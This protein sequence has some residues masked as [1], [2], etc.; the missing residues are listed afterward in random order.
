MK[1]ITK[2]IKRIVFITVCTSL[3]CSNIIMADEGQN[4]DGIDSPV[5]DIFLNE[6]NDL[7]IET[8]DV[9][10]TS[11]ITYKTEGLTITQIG[12]NGDVLYQIPFVEMGVPQTTLVNGIETNIFTIPHSVIESLAN[13][14][15]SNFAQSI[16]DALNGIGQCNLRVDS[17]MAVYHNGIKQPG[18]YGNV[19]GLY[20]SMEELM[21]AEA[22]RDRFGIMTH[23]NWRLRLNRLLAENELPDGIKP[24]IDKNG[25]ISFGAEELQPVVLDYTKDLKKHTTGDAK[26]GV[27]IGQ[28][29]CNSENQ[30]YFETGNYSNT[31]NVGH[32]IPSSEYLKNEI[33]YSNW[34]AYADVWGRVEVRIDGCPVTFKWEAVPQRE[35]TE[36]ITDANG[37]T[38]TK[39]IIIPPVIE[40]SD[41]FVGGMAATGFEFFN[42]AACNKF[43][44]ASVY[45]RAVNM[46]GVAFTH[47]GGATVSASIDSA[48]SKNVNYIE[49]PEQ[50]AK[51]IIPRVVWVKD[52][53][54]IIKEKQ[55]LE[56]QIGALYRENTKTK[57][58]FLM[59]DG[60]TLMN[61]TKFTGCSFWGDLEE[62][63][64][65]YKEVLAMGPEGVVGSGQTYA[66]GK[67]TKEG[68]EYLRKHDVPTGSSE[69]EK[70]IPP[71]TDN[72]N[73]YTSVTLS[74]TPAMQKGAGA[75][76]FGSGSGTPP[77]GATG[78]STSHCSRPENEPVFV[79][80]PVVSPV[81]IRNTRDLQDNNV[82]NSTSIVSKGNDE[83]NN[84]NKAYTQLYRDANNIDNDSTQLILDNTYYIHWD[85]D[86]IS[87]H[88]KKISNEPEDL[89]GYTTEQ[90]YK[91]DDSSPNHSGRHYDKYVKDKWMKFPFDVVYD[92]V[93][94][95]TSPK[96][97]TVGTKSSVG[98]TVLNITGD[99]T[100]W[101]KIKKPNKYDD[102]D[103]GSQINHWRN[104]PFYIPS[105][106]REIKTGNIYYKS[107]A[108]NT[109]GELGK[110]FDEL[111]E[112]KNIHYNYS[113]DGHGASYVATFEVPVQLS[114]IIYDFTITGL[115][116]GGVYQSDASGKNINA[117]C[118]T[119][120]ELKAGPLNRIGSPSIRY[121]VDGSKTT[122][123]PVNQTLIMRDGKSNIWG[124]M[125][126]AWKGTNISFTIKTIAN[127]WRNKGDYL[128]I[129]P[130]FTLV[131]N[132][133]K[134]LKQ[135]DNELKIYYHNTYGSGRFI[136]YG[137]KEDKAPENWNLTKIADK[138]FDKSYYLK[139][140]TDTANG[141]KARLYH[142]G[143]WANYSANKWNDF[144]GSS[145]MTETEILN[146][147]S[148][149]NCLSEI[150]LRPEL[151]LLSGEYEQLRSNIKDS[152]K[153]Y[154][155]LNTYEKSGS[156]NY[157]KENYTNSD[158][159]K[160]RYSMQQ[161]FGQYNIPADL[162]I[163][164]NKKYQ[165]TYGTDFD[166]DKY[167]DEHNGI[168]E[169]DKIFIKGGY[170][171][172]NFDIV[173]Y[174]EGKP[175]LV[176]KG[177][178]G[179][180]MWQKEG[181]ENKK[182][183]DDPTN[184]DPSNPNGPASEYKD[185]DV[186]VI[187]LNRNIKDK[188]SSGLFNVN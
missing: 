47:S 63:R 171:I 71:T 107:E 148:R 162:F 178:G 78:I 45:T 119:K 26:T 118:K 81:S 88:L 141:G 7:C 22:W 24:I 16:I 143:N 104:T 130:R 68:K 59:I 64:P 76:E 124:K 149:S 173:A 174:E 2:K 99:Y 131:T 168:Q 10:R 111:E 33:K 36:T 155:D 58:D 15:S 165:E 138:T 25:K 11:N 49:W 46:N 109:D 158:R 55:S 69:Q 39:T 23:F 151:R 70:Q 51:D 167:I 164:D 83:L 6:N 60:V 113:L 21:N 163:V 187:D 121:L 97:E 79:H 19:D 144:G 125:G 65:T 122:S 98:G 186:I 181:Y 66:Y 117:L 38:T 179:G 41:D 156:I 82:Y 89:D 123:I 112:E 8:T 139:D 32:G 161:W 183:P 44:S 37:N 120:Q 62:E 75:S 132:K 103:N 28:P 80:T 1:Q 127:M 180:N 29:T 114:G 40:S 17:V 153:E 74:Y 170:L 95:K 185:G 188:Y 142:F 176:Y 54:A 137:S 177:N 73:Y 135:T 150:I 5:K 30:P 20:K 146:R 154:E 56:S 108:I 116:N 175:H 105:F 126:S 48:L 4:M 84:S 115:A 43:A 184:P 136:E 96:N 27:G 93:L 12:D 133:G 85:D 87:K 182:D 92:G 102:S 110:H 13:D 128:R 140:M 160:F 145:I 86:E 94:Y 101:I 35:E 134:V 77:T 18:L 42:A 152:G 159:D 106:A 91:S 34:H 52:S 9:H 57:N 31:Y 50:S 14:I 53:S 169:D 3:L 100:E 147:E 129:I 61:N 67:Q 90:S 172:V 157:I 166:L 72:G